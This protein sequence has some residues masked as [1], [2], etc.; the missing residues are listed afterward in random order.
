MKKST[1]L[2]IFNEAFTF[3]ISSLDINKVALE[4][5]VLNHDRF[6]RDEVIGVT[7]VGANVE[8]EMGRMHWE[9]VVLS[10]NQPV[11][12]W[13]TLVQAASSGRVLRRKE[14]PV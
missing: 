1:V 7:Y 4:I 2:P 6:G 13:H 5:Q 9:E 8:N 12:R 3:D 10:P 11:S 14:Q